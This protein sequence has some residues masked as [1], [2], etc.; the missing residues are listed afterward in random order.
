MQQAETCTETYA[1]RILTFDIRGRFAHPCILH[2]QP[3]FKGV[4]QEELSK[5]FWMDNQHKFIQ[6]IIC[7]A[8]MCKTNQRCCRLARGRTPWKAEVR[9]IATLQ[10][11]HFTSRYRGLLCMAG[12]TAVHVQYSLLIDWAAH[13]IVLEIILE[14][15]LWHFANFHDDPCSC[16]IEKPW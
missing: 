9:Y 12:D 11:A 13:S 16:E 14:T 5:E 4:V 1:T 15:S 8:G 7:T 10:R 6:F 2:A 3:A